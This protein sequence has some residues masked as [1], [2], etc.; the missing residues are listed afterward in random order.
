MAPFVQAEL[1]PIEE[2]TLIPGVR[3]DYFAPVKQWSADPRLV[4]RYQIDEDWVAKGGIGLV[5][6]APQPDETDKT[7]GNPDLGL[8]HAIHYAVGAEW[9]PRKY[10][11]FDATLYYKD[12]G[13]LVSRTAQLTLRDGM[14][15]PQVYDNNGVGRAYGLELYI[16]HDIAY[17]LSGWLTYTLSRSERKDSGATDYRLFDFDQTHIFNLIISYRFQENW[18]LGIRLRIISGNPTTPPVG[19]VF[20]SDFDRYAQIPGLVNSARLPL[21]HTLDIRCEK[22]WIYDTWTFYAYLHLV[23]AYNHQNVESMVYNFD[24]SQSK[25]QSGLPIF[26]ILGLR[27]EL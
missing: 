21:Y 2:L 12:M 3:V 4:A 16:K 14:P 26:P 1:R 6:Q 25:P 22:R 8:E 11:F 23:N 17:N 9:R 24:F 20:M 10:L 18:M 19:S 7:F 5:H 15:V 13:S 27:A